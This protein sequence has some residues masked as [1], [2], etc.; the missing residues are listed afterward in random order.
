MEIIDAQIHTWLSDRPRR[1][2]AADYRAKHR[3]KLPYLIHA[4]QTNTTEMALLEMAEVG[5]DRA[6]LTPNG[7]YGTDN[8]YQ[9]EGA[10]TYA[11]KFRVVG[12][13]DY[14]ADDVEERL[15]ADIA[16][17]MVGVR[18]MDLRDRERHERGEFTRVLDACQ[19]QGCVV[20]LMV[21]HPL[22]ELLVRTLERYEGI[23]FV[24]GHLGVGFAP[25]VLGVLP[26]DPF[27][28]LPAVLDLAR[29][30]N[31]HMNLTGAPSLSREEFPFR[32]VW[33][34]VNRIVDAYGADRVMWGSDYTRTSGL[35][36]YWDGTH[37]LREVSGLGAGELAE[38]YGATLRQVYGWQPTGD[39]I[40]AVSRGAIST[41]NVS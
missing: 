30:G 40:R 11:S 33:D 32:D 5:V 20:S 29:L 9:L 7:V 18:I 21:F 39:Q 35:H 16:R 28:N 25:P 36:S 17:G 34:G 13:I 23:R 3:D 37:Y 8:S 31:V 2:W 6:L 10:A 24:I 1:P 22:P 14:L 12:W 26:E 27:E 38:I 41:V 19:E 15:A 4:G